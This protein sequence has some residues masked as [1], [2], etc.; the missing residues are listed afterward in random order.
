MVIYHFDRETGE[1]LCSGVA[2]VD[3][4]EKLPVVPAHSTSAAPPAVREGE[5][6][7]WVDDGWWTIVEDHRGESGYLDGE[8]ITV[9]DLGPLPDGW[10]DTPPA[11][12]PPTADEV[13]EERDRRL[14]EGDKRVLQLARQVREAVRGGIDTTAM[15]ADLAAWD[16][17]QT[18]LCNVPDQPGFPATVEWP[19]PPAE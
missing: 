8:P 11:P 2:R 16:A 13:R 6:A 12:A 5:A 10:S 9:S 15:E 19:V 3:P 1:Y 18:A 14:R 17:H 7:V 4:L